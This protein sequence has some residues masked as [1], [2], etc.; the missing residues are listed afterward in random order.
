M[1]HH[2]ISIPNFHHGFSTSHLLCEEYKQ[3]LKHVELG[4]S[5]GLGIHKISQKT[6]F[7]SVVQ[8]PLLERVQTEGDLDGSCLPLPTH[9]FEAFYPKGS[10]SPSAPIPGGF[11]FYMSGPPELVTGREA[12]ASYRVMFEKDWE[13]VKGGKLPGIFGGVGDLAYKCSGGRQDDRCK[14]FDIRLM[15]R[16]GGAGELYTYLPQTENNNTRLLAVPPLSRANN[17]YGYSVGRGSFSFVKG[18]WM[19]ISLRVKMNC[20]GQEDG[21]LELVVD[22]RS[23]IC[24]HG[25]TLRD[26][27][28]SIIMGMHFQTFFGGHGDD[29]AS[30]KDQRA[31]FADITSVSA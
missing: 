21:E 27:E 1:S 29:W 7:P 6:G 9:A 4:R 5:K 3:K 8:P 23:V 18:R 2:L 14:C 25:V 30:P 28:E 11:G 20:I 19:C 22:G 16:Q 13:W 31:W 10:V 26:S 17:D 15:W 24:V 12:V